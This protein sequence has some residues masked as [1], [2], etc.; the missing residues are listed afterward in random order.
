MNTKN[1]KPYCFNIE[2][3][4]KPECQ[5]YLI[6]L[7]LKISR[8]NFVELSTAL[9]I[10]ETKLCSVHRNQDYLSKS[11]AKNIVDFLFILCEN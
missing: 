9:L 11:E 5:G 3:R 10:P 7:L 4:L 2:F 8:R 1:I 6:D